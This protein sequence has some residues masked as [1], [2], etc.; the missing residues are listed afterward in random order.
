MANISL[1]TLKILIISNIVI[2]LIA[3]AT[4]VIALAMKEYIIAIVMFIVAGWEI[5]NSIKWKRKWL[6]K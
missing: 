3:F 4:G 6:K 2:G 5:A 1:K